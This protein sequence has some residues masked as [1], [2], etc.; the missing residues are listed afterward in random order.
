MEL[1]DRDLNRGL[2]IA[3]VDALVIVGLN[4]GLIAVTEFSPALVG[5]MSPWNGRIGEGSVDARVLELGRLLK[6]ESSVFA[7]K[8]DDNVRFCALCVIDIDPSTS[9][10]GPNEPCVRLTWSHASVYMRSNSSKDAS[11]SF[12][13][14]ETIEFLTSKQCGGDLASCE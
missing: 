14:G 11:S 12:I 5:D 9:I 1:R 6:A 3:S 4:G 13:L 10:V 2:S 7:N 8:G